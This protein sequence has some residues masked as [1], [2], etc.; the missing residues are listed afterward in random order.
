MD[1]LMLVSF[2]LTSTRNGH[3]WHIHSTMYKRSVKWNAAGVSKSP[4]L[5]PPSQSWWG[6]E[7]WCKL[8]GGVGN[9]QIGHHDHKP[10][11][12]STLG[13]KGPT[14]R[15]GSIATVPDRA[16]VF[17]TPGSEFPSIRGQQWLRDPL[18]TTH[19]SLAINKCVLMRPRWQ[20]F[21]TRP[22]STC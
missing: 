4:P 16:R 17:Q 11:R 8:I 19:L 5:S 14:S 6:R 18:R 1:N 12:Y 10:P 22:V 20:R 21:K 3:M 15:G 13:S 7:V 2:Q 9:V